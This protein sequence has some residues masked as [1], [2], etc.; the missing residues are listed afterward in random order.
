M[1]DNIGAPSGADVSGA[2]SSA[3]TKPASTG[4]PSRN[5]IVRSLQA[6]QVE[7]P[8]ADPAGTASGTQ[9]D[10]AP[11]ADGTANKI[12][13]DTAKL[14]AGK[15]ENRPNEKAKDQES[16]P[17]AAFKERLGKEKE[18]REKIET[19]LHAARG[20]T[21][22]FRHLFEV[23]VQETERL[24]EQARTGVAFDER[25]EE[26]QSLKLQQAVE[27]QLAAKDIEHQKAFGQLQRDGKIN[28]L[29]AQMRSE[30][31]AA[32]A[33]FPLVSPAEVRAALRGN[34][35]ADIRSL[36]QAK[37]EERMAY[38]SKQGSASSATKDL[39]TS[40]GKPSG[41]SRFEA[42]LSAKGMSQ[43]FEAARAKR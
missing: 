5:D 12:E 10:G 29:A 37:H 41:V 30:V 4:R 11:R 24:T 40:V 13:G 27:K 19:D 15:G 43:A 14:E 3:T 34:P 1:T 21:A 32:C 25:S 22:K 9:T 42:P 2:S 7:K 17:L 33:A 16:V 6:K 31:A 38:V 36:A 8:P 20:E 39:P 23:A 28:E 18:R 35:D 26:L